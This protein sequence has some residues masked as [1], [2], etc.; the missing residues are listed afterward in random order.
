M[1]SEHT[2]IASA[3]V[4]AAELLVEACEA[5]DGLHLET[6]R[7]LAKD[8]GRGLSSLSAAGTIDSLVE[9][10]IAC[11]DLAT[12]A[13]CNVVALPVRGRPTAA[14]ATHLAAGAA[15]ALA[16]LAEAEIGAL[17]DAHAENV[18]RDAGSAGW[19]ADLAVRQIG[20]AG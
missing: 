6:V 4:L 20:E 10:T 1:I 2:G 3:G 8:L 11:A 18:L 7:D 13:A 12:L 14:A 9:A 17:E 15:R 5:G 19:K 16:A